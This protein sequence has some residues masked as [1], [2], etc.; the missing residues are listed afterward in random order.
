MP[1][2]AWALK[3]GTHCYFHANPEKVSELGA[4]HS[5]GPSFDRNREKRCAL[6]GLGTKRRDTLLLPRASREGVRAGAPGTEAKGSGRARYAE[7]AGGE[8]A[9]REVLRVSHALALFL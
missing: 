7:Q 6:H 2:T 5:C 3:G 8:E 9:Y 1:C 4:L